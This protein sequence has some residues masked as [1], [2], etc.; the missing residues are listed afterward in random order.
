[1]EIMDKAAQLLV[2]EMRDSVASHEKYFDAQPLIQAMTM[3]VIGQ[4]AFG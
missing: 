1:M 2:L 3:N 4:S